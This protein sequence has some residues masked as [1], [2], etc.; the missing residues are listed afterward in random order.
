MNSLFNIIVN[1]FNNGPPVNRHLV[2]YPQQQSHIV[3]HPP[4]LMYAAPA[5]NFQQSYPVQQQQQQSFMFIPSQTRLQQPWIVQPSPPPPPAFIPPAQTTFHNM[6][7]SLVPLQSVFSSGTG[8]PQPAF[9]GGTALSQQSF[10]TNSNVPPPSAFASG[11]GIPQPAFSGG[12]A[13]LKRKSHYLDDSE[14]ESPVDL[15]F[16][17]K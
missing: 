13:V 14:Y 12:T 3:Q 9:S 5:Q 16:V 6:Q 8:I 10:S 2:L 11:T 4:T 17:L 7:P 15:A 1:Q